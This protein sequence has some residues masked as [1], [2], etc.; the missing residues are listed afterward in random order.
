MS[1]CIELDRAFGFVPR[2]LMV[3]ALGSLALLFFFFPRHA[4][5]SIV[6]AMELESGAVGSWAMSHATSRSDALFQV[7]GTDGML[8]LDNLSRLSYHKPNGT[9]HALIYGTRH[10]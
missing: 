5:D 7:V 3:V 6:M 8:V 2:S 10:T 1:M 9:A 4:A